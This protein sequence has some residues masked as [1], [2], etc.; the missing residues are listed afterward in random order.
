MPAKPLLVSFAVIAAL[1]SP[2]RAKEVDQFT[3]R[4]FALAHLHDAAPAIDAKIDH[5]LDALAAEL[6]AHGGA[7]DRRLYDEFQGGTFELVAQLSTPFETWLRDAADVD[8]FWVDDR[9]MYGGAIDYDDMGLGWYVEIAPE[10]RIGPRLVGIDKLGHFIGQ[11][12]FY[13]REYQRLRARD[14]HATP[15][16]LDRAIRIYGHGLEATF[17]GLTGTGVYSYA[18]L[19]ANWQGLEFYKQVYGGAHPYLARDGRG[20]WRR[21][22]DFH[23]AEYATDAWDEV[24][25]PSC[26]RAAPLYAKVVRYLRSH[27][28]DAYRANSIAFLNATGITQDRATYAASPAEGGFDGRN[29]FALDRVCATP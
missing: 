17:L 11:G 3:D 20:R 9:G 24:Q 7:R 6:N 16:A 26:A 2:A 18:D 23:I 22:R 27:A 15:A 4:A 28:C 19:A 8:L 25:N 13:Y 14:P 21:V 29:A 12:W 10:L 5:M 1:A